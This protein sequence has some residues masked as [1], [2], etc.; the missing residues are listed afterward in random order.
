MNNKIIPIYLLLVCGGW[1]LSGCSKSASPSITAGVQTLDMPATGGEAS[2]TIEANKAWTV[3]GN[4]WIMAT[5]TDDHT[6][7]LHVAPNRQAARTANIICVAETAEAVITV[8]QRETVT[9]VQSDSLALVALYRAGGGEKWTRRWF[10][11]QSLT[12]WAG[13]ERDDDG[14]VVGLSLNENNLSG[15]LP[16]DLRFL[17]K[18]QY[19]LLNNNSL[20]GAIPDGVN[21]LTGLEILDLSNNGFTGNIPHM[22]ALIG[23]RMLDLSENGFTAAAIPAF[24]TGLTQLE[25][26]RLKHANLTG[27]LP[28]GLQALTKLHTLD[29]SYNAFTGSIPDDWAALD[30]LRVL[31][32]YHA[33]LSGSIPAF[34]AHLPKL[35]W[36]ALDNNN[37]TGAI[38]AGSYAALDKLWLNNNSLTGT[39]PAAIKE[40][41]KWNTFHVCSGNSLSDCSGDN[42]NPAAYK[43][44]AKQYK[45]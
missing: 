10:L 4:D 32:L 6:V 22:G 34:I 45:L 35:E 14:R 12:Q 3:T 40:N 44:S 13:V 11:S 29:L 7:T 39:I 42:P 1:L 26:L 38:P 43:L 21:H 41:P 36:L 19:C 33:S 2:V 15:S 17:N 25:D 23:L 28:A 37:L 5:K 20:S 30:N 31:Y 18:L 27:T 16:D 24:L 9:A 8:S